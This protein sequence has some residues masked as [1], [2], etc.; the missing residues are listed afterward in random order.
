MSTPYNPENSSNP[1]DGLNPSNPSG[2][3]HSTG[4]HSG[5]YGSSD[6]FGSYGAGS[7][8]STGAGASD[9]TTSFGAQNTGAQGS[10]GAGGFGSGAQGSYGAGGFGSGASTNDTN[11]ATGGAHTADSASGTV[12]SHDASGFGSY[13]QTGQQAAYGDQYGQQQ[14]GQQAPGAQGTQYGQQAPGA[15]GAQFGQGQNQGFGAFPQDAPVAGKK[16]GFFNALFDF[17]F[18]NFITIDFVKVLYIIYIVFAALMWLGGLIVAFS[19][20]GESAGVGLLMLFGW[21]IFGTL[22]ALFQIVISRVML[23]VLVS[24]VRIAQNTTDLVD[25]GEKK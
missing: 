15:Q 1:E 22:W 8:G 23:E 20:F 25:Q 2:S 3:D 12:A 16:N 5:S 13:G 6:T 17:S 14:Y 21:L 24:V 19:G 9:S 7:A 18:R 10:Y 11:S 4:A